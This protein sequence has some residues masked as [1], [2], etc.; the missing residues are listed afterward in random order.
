[1]L[2]ALRMAFVA[3]FKRAAATAHVQTWLALVWV[4]RSVFNCHPPN[5][6]NQIRV[7]RIMLI[8]MTNIHFSTQLKVSRWIG[9]Y[10][11]MQQ[12]RY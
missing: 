6:R 10:E 9:L 5:P 12:W 1:M 3:S 2:A 11:P 7:M 8:M 4:L